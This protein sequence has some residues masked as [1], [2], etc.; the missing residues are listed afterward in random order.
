[1]SWPRKSP[2]IPSPWTTEA[3]LLLAEKLRRQ[4]ARRADELARVREQCR[5]LRGYLLH[6]WPHVEPR[7]L[8]W[9]R[10]LDVACEVLEDL[11]AGR[12]K[13]LV[14][15]LPPGCSK[16]LTFSVLW[17][18]WEWTHSPHR[19]FLATSYSSDLVERDAGLVR[20]L[21][22][23]SW[24]RSLWP[25]SAILAG[26]V[27]RRD[28]FRTTAGGWRISKPLRGKITGRHSDRLIVD[29]PLK[30]DEAHQDRK[31][32]RRVRRLITETLPSRLLP[33]ASRVLVMQRL[34]ALDPT[35]V[36]LEQGATHVCLP[37][38][39]ESKHPFRD[40]RDWRSVD[41]ELLFPEFMTEEF[42]RA[43]Q[44]RMST[45][46]ISG[47]EQ[48]RPSV[49]G[50]AVFE[51]GWLE[52]SWDHPR[53][54]EHDGTW[55]VSVDCAFDDDDDADWVVAQVWCHHLD[56]RYLLVHEER[57]QWNVSATVLAVK[58]ILGAA[59]GIRWS[60]PWIKHVL[61]EKA[62]NGVAVG[63]R[64]RAEL[65][66]IV[67]VELLPPVGSKL[68]R[69]RSV[70][71]LFRSSVYS[72]PD[73][74]WCEAWRDELEAFPSGAFDDRVDATSQALAWLSGTGD[75]PR[76]WLSSHAALGEE[77]VLDLLDS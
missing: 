53:P 68:A 4:D 17:P 6:A 64:L 62:A 15:N 36:F 56:G 32:L 40:K 22:R 33:G 10:H 29:D 13:D 20:A 1:M 47:Q 23:S 69:A 16:S 65:A 45:A 35:A 12:V 76:R 34:H 51:R 27:D 75:Y 7:P 48:Q 14:V 31:E 61:I 21:M 39:F 5:S 50:G 8:V 57:G 77:N 25:R 2:A 26:G 42:V 71:P 19:R 73:A 60:F 66:G 38:R 37:Q 11:T 41:G 28:D 18:S 59:P 67:N 49:E 72:H 3:R 70:E 30:P 55:C 54:G 46:A 58:R 9:G 63:E 74:A 44:A 52:R 24:W 43:R